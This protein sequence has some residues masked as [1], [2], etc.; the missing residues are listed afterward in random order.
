MNCKKYSITINKL[1]SYIYHIE[2]TRGLGKQYHDLQIYHDL[3]FSLT[4]EF[5][6]YFIKEQLDVQN[7]NKRN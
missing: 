2:I 3:L 5:K 4:C 1:Y 6:K 7:W